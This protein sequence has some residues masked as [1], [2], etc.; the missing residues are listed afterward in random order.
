M[1][2]LSRLRAG[3][4]HARAAVQLSVQ[5]ALTQYYAPL[6]ENYGMMAMG[7]EQEKL[8]AMIADLLEKNLAVENRYMPGY[9]DLYGFEVEN[10]SVTPLFNLS[11]DYV[12]EQQITQFMKYRAP[13]STISNF[14]EKLKAMNTFMA[15][16]GLIKKSMDLENKLQKI[17]RNRYI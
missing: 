10:V 17:R 4:K 5:S 2:D 13:V 12:L 7:H 8:E 6:K 15:Q 16:S 9:T 1:V 11:E 14:V 3:E